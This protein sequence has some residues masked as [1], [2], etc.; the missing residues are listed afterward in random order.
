MKA[1][2]IRLATIACALFS[3]A[4]LS[5]ADEVGG[6]VAARG[7]VIHD[8][9]ETL[10]DWCETDAEGR[11]WLDVPGDLRFELIPSITD[12]AIPNPGDGQ[13]HPYD[14]SEVHAAL[15][16][17]RFPLDGIHAHVFVL[18]YPRRSGFES[19]AAPGLILLAPG[20]R[21]IAREH[22]HAELIHELG[23]VIQYARM[24]DDDAGGWSRYRELRGLDETSYTPSSSHAD[25]PHEIFAEDF[26][27][28]F[29]GGLANTTGSIENTALALPDA[30]EGL[31]PFLRALASPVTPAF[32][33]TLHAAPNP[34]RGA[35]EFTRTAEIS[36]PLEL[37]DAAGRRLATL[38]AVPSAGV[39]RWR[40]DG[41]DFRGRR[42]A[43]GVVFARIR[44]EHAPASRVTL[45]P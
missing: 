13:F 4:S 18:P 26:R 41:R 33:L 5:S 40:W 30:V 36:A 1:F 37:Y 15:A 7:L 2:G 22:Q 20:V 28:L 19:A 12:P 43:S 38:A 29:G 14:V 31:E 42:P 3:M 16:S 34:S 45:L 10:R 23:H 9:E 25:R 6:T 21:P 39:T 35:M 11:V 44:G 17:V 8:A 24:P 32:A 27:Y